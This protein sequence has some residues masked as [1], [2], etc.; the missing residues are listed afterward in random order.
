MD[1]NIILHTTPKSEL[2]T[3]IAE[4][5]KEQFSEL[6]SQN[7]E[8][9]TRLRTRREVAGMLGVSLPTLHTWTKEGV[10]KAVRIG[11]SV[12]TAPKKSKKP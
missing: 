2:K 9:D 12:D 3:L 5:V 8:P 11:Q 7:K 10:I 1:T 4:A 6:F